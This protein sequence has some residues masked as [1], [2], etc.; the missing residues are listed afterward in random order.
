MQRRH[1]SLNRLARA[2]FFAVSMVFMATAWGQTYPNRP[3]RLVVPFP[4]GGSVDFVAR[5]IQPA[6]ASALGQPVVIDNK[7]GAGGILAAEYVARQPHDGYTLL[8]GT[9]SIMT[10]YPI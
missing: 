4:P 3:I 5:A 1:T 2:L 9:A 7:G 10:V 6:L 8:L